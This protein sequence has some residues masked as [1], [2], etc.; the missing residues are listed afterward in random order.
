VKAKLRA[1]ISGPMSGRPEWNFPAFRK[2]AREWRK[3]GWRVMDP[4]RSFG[5]RTD[6]PRSVY[7]RKDVAMLLRVDAVVVL[8][9]WETSKGA[10]LEVEIARQ[11]GL[12]VMDWKSGNVLSWED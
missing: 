11:L 12:D 7:M 1:Y 2:A 10:R 4:S 9:G 3:R 8:D 5:G 6:L